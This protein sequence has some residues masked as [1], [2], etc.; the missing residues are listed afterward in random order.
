MELD[1]IKRWCY[2]D[3]QG[4]I[5]MCGRYFVAA[6]ERTDEL[7]RI[8]AAAE[9]KSDAE[10]KTGEVF[11][12]DSA[13]VLTGRGACVMRWGFS[14][15]ER[16]GRVINARSETVDEKPLFRAAQG[17]RVLVPASYFFEWAKQGK[18]R[19]KCRIERDAPL[20]Y[21]AGLYRLENREAAFCILTCPASNAVARIHDRMP[22]LL[23]GEARAAWLSGGAAAS[24]FQQALGDVRVVKPWDQLSFL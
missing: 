19:V 4:V 3:R 8:L 15:F 12:G 5:R 14:G 13:A 16:G 11:P 20:L 18:E 9:A 6:E 21:M 24:V 17:Q 10:P 22:V 23:D 1:G 2:A 7:L